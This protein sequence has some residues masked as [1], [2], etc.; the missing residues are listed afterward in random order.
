MS[1][2]Y[3]DFAEVKRKVPIPDVL[4]PLD[5]ADNFTKKGDVYTGQCPIHVHGPRPNRQQFKID[6]RSGTW[7]WH[8]FGDCQ[9]GGDVIELVKAVTQLSDQHV[10][11]WFADHFGD[12][13]TETKRRDTK[14]AG[15]DEVQAQSEPAD[16]N[17]VSIVSADKSAG[18]QKPLKPL[19]FRLNLDVDA[20]RPYL[21]FRGVSDEMIARYG[22]GLCRKGVLA[23]YLAIPIHRYPRR[24]GEAAVAYIGRWPG[25]DFDPDADRPRYKLPGG[26][27]ASQ[28][29]YGLPEALETSDRTP[30]IIVEGPFKVWHLVQAGFPGAV[31]TLTASVSEEQAAIL[32]QTGRGI[33]L[34]FDGNE[35]GYAGMRSAA[36][37][38]ITQTYVRVVRLPDGVEPD[39]LAGEQL[40]HLL[41]FARSC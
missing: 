23:G 20:A 21:Q 15:R 2:P 32:A 24:D 17:A 40:K 29:V 26:F 10:R 9:R 28:V 6:R 35:A 36:G 38:L 16:Q 18:K 25:A 37:K 12:R 4:A 41:E 27:P 14:K 31:S 19:R 7:L 11:F 1:R 3:I 22:L 13:L 5:I 30:L 33:I 8:C 39:Q 34:L